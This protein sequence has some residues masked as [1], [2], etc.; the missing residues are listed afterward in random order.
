M[1]NKK[2][3]KLQQLEQLLIER[4][5]LTK[6]VNALDKEINRVWID[7]CSEFYDKSI[8]FDARIANMKKYIAERKP[9]LTERMLENLQKGNFQGYLQILVEERF[10]EEV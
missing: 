10:K 6:Q 9:G 4:E 7:F 8:G 3:R 1:E 2:E 5:A